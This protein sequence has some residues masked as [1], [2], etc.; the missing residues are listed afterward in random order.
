MS[1]FDNFPF[2][3]DLGQ[4]NHDQSIKYLRVVLNAKWK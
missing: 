3:P 2:C 4:V 1:Q